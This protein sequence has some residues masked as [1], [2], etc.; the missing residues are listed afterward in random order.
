M[1]PVALAR[2]VAAGRAGL[3]VALL[4]APGPIGRRWLGPDARRPAARVA[5]RAMGARDVAIGLGALQALATDA[6]ARA[7]LRA[8]AVGDATD[9][10]VTL[11]ARRDLPL[12]GTVL[13]SAM[14]TGGTAVGAWLQARVP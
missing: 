3:G 13:V 10:L 1:E 11:R 2:G 8:G 7:W 14:A 6:P 12:L 9:V 5:L 4:V